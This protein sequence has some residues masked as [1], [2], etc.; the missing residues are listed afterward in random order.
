M[1]N[2]EKELA[3]RLKK[4][5]TAALGEIIDHYTAYVRTVIFNFSRGSI[6]EQDID[7][8]CSD[9]FY[10][11]WRSREKLDIKIGFRSYLSAIARNAVKDRL[12]SEKMS[13]ENID[14]I[15]ELEEA[16]DF[17]VET[18]AE[19]NEMLRCIDKRLSELGEK[20]RMIFV[21]FY[22][23][24]ETTAEIAQEMEISE[25]NVRSSLSRTRNKLK[26]Y[27]TE[28]GFDHA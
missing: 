14:D 17:S 13:C 5:N 24:G 9:V 19:L 11:L 1:Q 10:S 21:R 2:N 27:L 28:R 26:D 23:Y 18:Q 8:I 3:K 12:R 6:P 22:F 20:E 7:D 25:S 15:S 16:G 4:S